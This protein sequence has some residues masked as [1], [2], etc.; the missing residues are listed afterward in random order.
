MTNFEQGNESMSSSHARGPQTHLFIASSVTYII[1]VALGSFFLGFFDKNG[2]PISPNEWGDVLAGVF[3]PLAFLW[4][5]YASL[6][7]RTELELQRNEL[8]QNNDSQIK[9]YEAMAAQALATEQQAKLLLQQALD[10][11]KSR[12]VWAR[13]YLAGCTHLHHQLIDYTAHLVRDLHPPLSHTDADRYFHINNIPNI[14]H[15]EEGLPHIHTLPEEVQELVLGLLLNLWTVRRT[16]D[17]YKNLAHTSGEVN[18]DHIKGFCRSLNG[19]AMSAWKVGV[20][21]AT[22]LAQDETKK[23]NTQQKVE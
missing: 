5:L 20:D 9:Q 7:Q 19:L 22:L 15:P 3:S 21:G 8:A 23:E 14:N 4:L 10:L 11:Q 12:I 1:F 13:W 17:N 2:A 16:C 6:S 18:A